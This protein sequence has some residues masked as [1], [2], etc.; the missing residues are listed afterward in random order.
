VWTNVFGANG[1]YNYTNTPG[2]NPAA[3]FLLVS[4]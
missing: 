1:S 4:P 2:V 3:F